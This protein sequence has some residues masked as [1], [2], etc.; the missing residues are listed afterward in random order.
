V[1]NATNLYRRPRKIRPA[2]RRG[3]RITAAN[4]VLETILIVSILRFTLSHHDDR[5]SG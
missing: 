1:W 4:L 3:Q 5:M 2:A